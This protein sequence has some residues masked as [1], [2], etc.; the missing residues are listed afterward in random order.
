MMLKLAMTSLT[1]RVYLYLNHNVVWHYKKL[2]IYF[3]LLVNNN[4]VNIK[5]ILKGLSVVPPDNI[6]MLICL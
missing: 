1:N 4:S 5:N 2:K 6:R 3:K